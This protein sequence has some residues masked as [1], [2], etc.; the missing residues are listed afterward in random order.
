MSSSGSLSSLCAALQSGQLDRRSFLQRVS[1]LGL[2]AGFATFLANAVAVSAEG[3]SRNGFAVYPGQDGTPTGTPVD[4]TSDTRPAIGMEGKT[5]GQDGDLNIIQ[6]QAISHLCRHKSSGVKDNLGCDIIN[7]PLMR[8]MPD[9]SLIPNLVEEVPSV[10]NGLLKEDLMEV[11]FNLRKGIL[12]SDGEPFTANDVRFTWEWVNHLDNGATTLDYWQDIADIEVVDDH[13]ARVTFVGAS[14]AWFDPFNADRGHIYPAHFWNGDVSDT[15]KTDE[16]MM[17]PVGTGPYVVESFTPND[18]AVFIANEHYRE[19]D[20]PAFA[21]VVIKG[22][23]DPTA[24]ARAVLQTGEYDY[25]WNLQVEPDVLASLMSDDAP[26]QVIVEAGTAVE[27]LNFQFADPNTEVDGQRSEMNTPHPILTDRAVR[28]AISLAIPRDLI[29]ERF[30]G[31]G[32]PATANILTG[33]DVFDSPNTSWGYNPERAAQVLDDAGWVLDGDVRAKDGVELR[34]TLATSVNSVRQ[35]TQAVIK[36]E[37]SKIGIQVTLEQVDAAV[38]FDSGA[39]NE[40][41]ISHFYWDMNMWATNA[42]SVLPIGYMNYWYAGENREN[43]AQ[44]SNSWGGLNHARWVNEEYDAALERIFTVTSMEEA[45]ELLIELN[46]IVI[47]DIAVIPLVNRSADT[48]G[49]SRSLVQE[50][51]A[52]GSGMERNYWNIANWNRTA[53]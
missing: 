6:W 8:T 21:R 28:E 15:A 25:A 1:A 16:F 38:Y 11:T 43:I 35:K 24:A 31:E 10:E 23:G 26:G 19:A 29:S 32:Q 42:Q 27:R 37:L 4:G 9:G 34:M 2:G 50:N 3:G 7:E 5:R 20:K 14:P 41:N 18:Q 46:D 22:G 48:Y 44:R 30:Y 53:E 45:M 39:G 47:G 49:I 17:S 13:T 51:V 52:L 40:Q 36:E 12:W 33:L